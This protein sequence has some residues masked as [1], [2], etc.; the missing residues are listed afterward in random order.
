[1]QGIPQRGGGDEA[2]PTVAAETADTPK[3]NTGT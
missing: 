2:G 1:M 3:I